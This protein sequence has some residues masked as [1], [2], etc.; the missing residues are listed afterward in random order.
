MNFEWLTDKR[1]KAFRGPSFIVRR[2]SENLEEKAC[3]SRVGRSGEAPT[4][5]FESG[6]ALYSLV[7]LS[8]RLGIAQ[9]SNEK[10]EANEIG[11]G[12]NADPIMDV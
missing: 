1:I 10:R 5:W 9:G 12:K 3:V 6:F 8:I 2:V 7:V 11:Y 4:G